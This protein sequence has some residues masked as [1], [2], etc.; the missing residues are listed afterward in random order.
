[1]CAP[2]AVVVL[3]ATL[4]APAAAQTGRVV[5]RVTVTV[6]GAARADASGVVV[7]LTGFREPP[8]RD[9]PVMLQR[10]RRFEPALL[11]VTAGQAVSFPNADPFFHN[12][13]SLSPGQRFDLGQ[14]RRG[15]TK[16]RL[17]PEP[18]PVE[19]YCNIHPEMAATILVLPNRRFA[20]TAADGSF[21]ID[22]VP[23]GVHKIYAYDRRSSAPEARLVTVTDGDTATV[24]FTVAQTRTVF[25]HKNKYGEAYRDPKKYR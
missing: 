4:A 9:V 13:F 3:A 2:V 11:A 18:G 6:D 8:P 19:V 22:G 1:V 10:G 17:F 23:R 14:Y 12:V 21:A 24:D 20:V 15:E 5:G 16:T 25:A 7:Y